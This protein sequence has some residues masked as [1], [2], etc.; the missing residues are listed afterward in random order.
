[1]IVSKVIIRSGQPVYKQV[2][3][4]QPGT[5]LVRTGQEVKM[6]DVIAETVFPEKFQV[7]DILN[8]LGIHPSRLEKHLKRLN[9]EVVRKGDVSAQKPG[10]ITRIFRASQD[11]RIVSM[12]EGRVALAMGER[13]LQVVAPIAGTV[14]ELI[15]GFGAVI[16]LT[17]NLIQGVWSN[18]LTASGSF[19]RLEFDFNDPQQRGQLPDLKDKIVYS[20]AI[21]TPERLRLLVGR[22]PA[23]IVLPSLVP[24]LV[25]EALSSSIALM[26]LNGFGDQ[27]IDP[28]SLGLLREMQDQEVFLLSD[29][30]GLAA[31]L[32]MPGEAGRDSALFDE[33]VALGVGSLVR[34]LG[35]PYLGST[36]RVVELPERAERFASGLTTKVAV[37]KRADDEQIRVPVTNLVLL[38]VE[39]KE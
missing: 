20:G 23:G 16:S 31:E 5:V 29:G 34:L 28:V 4:L 24:G 11:G 7:F 26:S 19:T 9:G 33:E 32:I 30:A 3:L 12:R 10:L 8:H 17:G 36:G 21:I 35:E 22:K 18:G 39:T 37:V 38:D 13:K 27:E 15:P 1:M 14:V 2:R 25:K 6:G